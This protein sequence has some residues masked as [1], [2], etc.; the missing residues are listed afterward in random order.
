MRAGHGAGE[1]TGA[2]VHPVLVRTN[3]A[4]EVASFANTLVSRNI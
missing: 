4:G 2:V 1:P 3:T